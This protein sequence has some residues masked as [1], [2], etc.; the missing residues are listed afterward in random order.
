[1]EIVGSLDPVNLLEDPDDRIGFIR[2]VYGILSA[3]LLV[4]ACISLIPTLNPQAR[5]WI[6]QNEAV[7]WT[8]FAV[9]IVTQC[10]LL[11]FLNLA[12]TVPYNYMLLFLFTGSEAY[13]VAFI[14]S[15]YP[16]DVVCQAAFM[17]A[18]VVIALTIYALRTKT[19][20]SVYGGCLY[21]LAAVMFICSLALIFLPQNHWL[22]VLYSAL[23][24]ILFG[25]YLIFDT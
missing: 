24:V 5:L 8:M 18:A 14:S 1:M 16:A 10:A 17:T 23:G 13:I 2:K 15:Q 21:I 20:F 11:C 7:I 6:G 19:D 22:T 4:T 25:F 12:R 9:S 3:Q